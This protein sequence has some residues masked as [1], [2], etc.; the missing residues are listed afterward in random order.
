MKNFLLKGKY[1]TFEK[2]WT[3]SCTS[4]LIG[5]TYIILNSSVL[6][7]PSKLMCLPISRRIVNNATLVLPA[8]VGAHKRMFSSEFR[9]VSQ[10]RL[11]IRL[12]VGYPSN[13][14]CAYCGKLVMDVKLCLLK[15]TTSIKK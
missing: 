3:I 14:G 12:S 2:F 6:I 8:P 5:A 1:Y 9:A 15:R 4:D 10:S 7:V 13:A 11:W